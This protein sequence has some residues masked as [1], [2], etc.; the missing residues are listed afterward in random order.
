MRHNAP[1][2]LSQS[3]LSVAGVSTS[4]HHLGRIPDHRLLIVSNHRSLFD[5]PL[6]MCAIGRPVRFACHYYMSQ[7]PIL[8]QAAMLMGAFPLESGREC[9]AS[10]FRKSIQF[11]QS[12]QL[13]GVFPE[14]AD[15]MVNVK[16]SHHLSPFHRGFAHLALKAP[17]DDLAVLPVAIA[18][19][20]TITLGI[21]SFTLTLLGLLGF[22]GC[23]FGSGSSLLLLH[24]SQNTLK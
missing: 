6:L 22:I 19:T 10:F 8:H 2:K 4:Y 13:V 12:N 18:F 14:G 24:E 7:V 11:L 16:P 1:L 23:C 9:Q 21:I 3:L 5:A 15:P 20:I 17:V